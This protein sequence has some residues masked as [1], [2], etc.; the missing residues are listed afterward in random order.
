MPVATEA[1]VQG[2]IGKACMIDSKLYAYAAVTA[3]T[4]LDRE[5]AFLEAVPGDAAPFAHQAQS[6][7]RAALNTAFNTLRQRVDPLLLSYARVLGLAPGDPILPRL[8]R[9]FADNSGTVLNRAFSFGSWSAGG[10]NAGTGLIYRLTKDEYNFTIES[11]FA[12]VKTAECVA[13]AHSGTRRH[14]EQF[15][16]RG[17]P[18]GRDSLERIGSGV[19]VPVRCM[20]ANSSSQYVQNP[21]F[22]NV[23]NGG[24]FAS[25]SDLTG[26]TMSAYAN[27]ASVT[28]TTY[29][30]NPSA[31]TSR[32]LR[33]NT[34]GSIYQ[35]FEQVR[36]NWNRN[37]PLFAQIAFYRESSCDGTLS[38]TIG[39]VT[40]SVALSAQSGWTILTFPITTNAWFK[41]W[42]TDAPAGSLTDAEIK[43]ELASRTTGTLLIDDLII[44]PYTPVDGAWV[45][46]V[47][48]ATPFIQRDVFTATDTSSDTGIVQTQ[49]A[50][51]Y[52]FYLPH[53]SGTPSWT[54]PT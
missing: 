52:G 34:N 51:A 11:G 10:S 47:G 17:K 35:T 15:M 39:G 23:Q 49:L 33:F 13:D 16:V 26:W 24:T 25:N 28:A 50:R 6:I 2:A 32:S 3:T 41:N 20:S 40:A 22:E 29:K 4:F 53:T 54:E 12:E 19:A 48:G 5:E 42:N 27:F 31:T 46:I 14:E 1:Q 18:A 9:Y 44:G 7:Q 37:V 45:A 8:Y 21:S 38:L 30:D 36:L 43:I